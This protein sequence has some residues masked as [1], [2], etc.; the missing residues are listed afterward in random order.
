MIVYNDVYKFINQPTT[1]QLIYNLQNISA[2]TIRPFADDD[3]IVAAET[4][5]RP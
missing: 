3:R 2:A 1:A 4:F 5:W